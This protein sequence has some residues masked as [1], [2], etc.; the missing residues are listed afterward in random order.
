MVVVAVLG[1]ITA[2][3]WSVT[4]DITAFLAEQD[5]AELAAI[6]RQLADSDLTRA[7]I[8]TVGGAD[9]EEVLAA[10][11]ELRG[12]VA[13]LP[14]VAWIQR[15][16]ADTGEA[17]YDL[18]YPRRFY[19]A[20]ERPEE[21][22]PAIFSGD[23]LTARAQELLRELSLPQAALVKRIAGG[24]PLMLFTGLVR[25]L[26]DAQSGELRPVGDNLLTEGG[27]AALFLR[28]QASPFD[29]AAM[30]PLAAGIAEAAA[31]V[32]E[33]HG[34]RLVIE[35][36]A[37]ARHALAAETSIRGDITRISIVSTIGLILVFLAMFRR[38]R[39]VVLVMLPLAVG[40]LAALAATLVIFGSVHGLTLAFGATLIGVAIDYSV[41]FFNHHMLEPDPAGPQGSVRRIWPG[42]LLGALTT[43]AGFIGLAWT[44]FPGL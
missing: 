12:E 33:A 43:I 40:V 9:E 16:V 39:L 7:W 28:T 34:G 14:G 17:F 20:S 23:G 35:E 26:S 21:E 3:R 18:Y 29:G 37:V 38:P 30:A 41:H 1:V 27:E 42:L 24:D 5:D 25:R 32:N 22:L 6:S 15:G 2:A 11:D 44:S 36:S 10:A 4:T 19:F 31:T 8:I 13:A